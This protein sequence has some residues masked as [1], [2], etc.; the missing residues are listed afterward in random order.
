MKNR[1]YENAL[2]AYLPLLQCNVKIG[3]EKTRN[4]ETTTKLTT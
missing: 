2:A 3:K 1:E 4:I